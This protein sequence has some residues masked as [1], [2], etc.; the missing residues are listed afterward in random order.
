MAGDT[1]RLFVSIPI[2]DAVRKSMRRIDWWVDHLDQ[3]RKIPPKNRH[4]TVV[5]IGDVPASAVDAITG[6]LEGCLSHQPAF[7]MPV[8]GMVSMPSER[9][10]RAL[11]VE[12]D[13][14]TGF[15]DLVIAVRAGLLSTPARE[16][17]LEESDREPRPHITVA[18]KK[19]SG[20]G[21]RVDV[22]S[23][24][25]FQGAIRCVR[26]ELVRSELTA[27]GPIYTPIRG[28]LMHG[29]EEE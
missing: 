24:P 29:S 18:R 28:W 6:A 16:R 23:A 3:F 13:A 12:L 7:A 9:R 4:V 5:F 26:V 15:G 17:L 27:N 2:D 14:S 21:G 19:R 25:V 20:G 11:A 22:A 8:I 10:Q 1:V